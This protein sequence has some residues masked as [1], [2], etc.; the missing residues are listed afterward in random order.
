MPIE[1]VYKSNVSVPLEPN[2][3]AEV[4]EIAYSKDL[5]RSAYIRIAIKEKLQ[6]D[7]EQQWILREGVING[8]NSKDIS[9]FN[10]LFEERRRKKDELTRK[11]ILF[12]EHQAFNEFF[13]QFERIHIKRIAD[14]VDIPAW[15]YAARDAKAKAQ[16]VVL[17]VAVRGRIDQ[18]YRARVRELKRKGIYC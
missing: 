5:S 3:I 13:P 2:L 8:K 10:K 16:E 18:C 6:R 4:E 12:L 14:S 7:K 1:R 17:G 15:K 9:F 11:K